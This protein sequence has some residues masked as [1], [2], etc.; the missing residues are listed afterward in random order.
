MSENRQE[1]CTDR[2]PHAT[3]R[4][5]AHRSVRRVRVSPAFCLVPAA[6]VA[7]IVLLMGF[8]ASPPRYVARAAFVVDW[9]SIPSVPDDEQ[10]QKIRNEWRNTIITEVTSLPHSD[11]EVSDILDRADDLSNSQ[12]D[13]AA[14]FSKLRR[15]LHVDLTSQSD[16]CDRFVIQMR[17]ND[18]SSAKAE[19]NWVL[20]GVVSRL[21]TESRIGSGAAILR[22]NANVEDVIQKE[23]ELKQEKQKLEATYPQPFPDHVQQRYEQIGAEP[24]KLELEHMQTG[25]GSLMNLGDAFL[26]DSIKVDEEVHVEKRSAGYGLGILFAAVCLGSMTGV[27]GLLMRRLASAVTMLKT[28]TS[29]VPSV[30]PVKPP[31]IGAPPIIN[32]K[33]NPKPLPL[34]PPLLP[35][36][37]HR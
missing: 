28:A 8:A 2:R 19:A 1:G 17:D 25:F 4:Q 31:A 10:A 29:G 33:H 35:S 23:D 24:N 20:L 16:D 27:A 9:K 12:T 7:G 15:W 32:R 21:K 34:P 11:E 30:I 5:N 26:N 22:S 14:A 37:A 13:K 18:P 36:A 6:I 3:A